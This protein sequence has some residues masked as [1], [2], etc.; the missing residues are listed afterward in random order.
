MSDQEQNELTKRIISFRYAFEGWAYV[1]RTQHNAWIHGAA[2]VA[3][4][5]LAFWL[6][7]SRVEWSILILTIA[8][9][10]LAEFTNTALEAVIDLVSPDYHPLAKTAKD[11][12]AGAVLVSACAAVIVG[13]I[14][15]GPPLWQRIIG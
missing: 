4:V 1:L 2:T 12:A 15:L 11:V 3:V 7:M 6:G 5:I 9:V 8:I 10:W 14:I 13:L